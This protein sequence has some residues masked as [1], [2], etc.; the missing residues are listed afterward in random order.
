MNIRMKSALVVCVIGYLVFSYWVI[1]PIGPSF[2]ASSKS[3]A[4]E[5]RDRICDAVDQDLLEHLRHH[6]S[7]LENWP[8]NR[9][10]ELTRCSERLSYK[11]IWSKYGWQATRSE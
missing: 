5:T 11:A 7:G 3:V 2:E 10:D 8:L 6:T 4:E 9:R 1:E